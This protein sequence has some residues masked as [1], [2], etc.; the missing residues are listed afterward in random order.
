[1]KKKNV[2]IIGTVGLPANYGGF[3]TL[4]EHLV[5]QLSATCNLSVYCSGKKYPKEKR[6]GS[7]KGARLIYLPWEANGIQSIVY[8]SISILHALWYADV[9]LILGV[10]GGFL[11]PFIKLFSRKKI[12][13]SI[14]GIE[15]KRNKWSKAARLYLWAAEWMAVKF[16]HADIS[17]NEAIQDYTAIRYKTLSNIVEYGA[18]HCLAVKPEKEDVKKYPF[19][20]RPYAFKVC[21][22]EPEN[23]LDMV[24][25]AFSQ[26]P[27]H[28]LVLVGNWNNSDY[29][30]KLR[31][32]YG[33]Y[34]NIIMLDPIYNQ[35]EL[36]MLRG[37]C[38]VYVHGHSAGGTNPSL[39]EAMYLGLPIMAYGVSYN[40]A[41]T[42][43]KALYFN[44]AADLLKLIDA[45]KRNELNEVAIAMKE[46][47]N[48]RYT[49]KLV[50]DKYAWL[51]NHV[52]YNPAKK[53]LMPEIAWKLH[54]AQLLAHGMGH[55]QTSALFY[56]KR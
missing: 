7:Y 42:E 26:R 29:G 38:Y 18:D 15:W 44:N 33:K 19:L 30:K 47:A 3:E 46:I 41:T 2:A 31:E 21:R 1:M 24:L 13:I 43:G 4:A 20:H 5:E 17:D 39:V 35:R 27:G 53:T 28:L 32:K 14:D 8:D 6:T 56:E 22:I 12:I 23:N 34:P 11:L 50:A 55:L 25:A 48:R 49:W 51:I 9:L 40:K 10:S 45:K 54:T 36:D 52:L 16:S 37:N